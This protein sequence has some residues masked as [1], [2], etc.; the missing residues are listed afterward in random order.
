MIDIILIILIPTALYKLYKSGYYNGVADT[1]QE[2][3]KD[4]E[5]IKKIKQEDRLKHVDEYFNNT[6][7]EQVVKDLEECGA[8]FV[9][10]Q[11][12]Q[13]CRFSY[14]NI[15][16]KGCEG[17]LNLFFGEYC[18]ALVRDI[19]IADQIRRFCDQR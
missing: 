3:I 9:D 12:E 13:P 14:V 4:K 11:E 15:T 16:T 18:I 8:E 17:W 10:Q 5:N 19:Y 1:Y 2:A 7:P 6:T